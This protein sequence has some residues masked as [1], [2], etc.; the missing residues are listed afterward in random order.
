[1]TVGPTPFDAFGPGVVVITRADITNPT[2]YNIG[3]AQEFQADFAANNKQ[4]F[5]QNQFPLDVARGTIKVTGKIKAALLSGYAW[6]SC[7]FGLTFAT[8]GW[9]WNPSEAQ[10][11]P[12][13]PYQVTVTNAG[14]FESDLGVVYSASNLPLLRVAS[15][16]ATGQYSVN[17]A[18][19]VYTFA[20]A[21]TTVPMLISYT[22]TVS[23]GQKL[24][25]SNQLMGTSPVFKLD[26]YTTRNSRPLVLRFNQCQSPKIMI[27]SKLEDFIMPEIDIEMYADTSQNIG[28]LIFPELS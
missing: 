11:V 23:S 28:T 7:F 2:P 26:Y 6:N 18:T 17:V 12:G 13:T 10:T 5:G 4:L 3:S 15:S 27:A 1:M 14:T 25:I 19:G 20:A 16:P 9:K 8:G 21:D 24:V 22:S